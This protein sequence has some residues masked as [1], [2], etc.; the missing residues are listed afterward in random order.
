[1]GQLAHQVKAFIAQT[2]MELPQ[3][4]VSPDLRKLLQNRG[5]VATGSRHSTLTQRFIYRRNRLAQIEFRIRSLPPW[6]L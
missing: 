5:A 1:M 6:V 3:S 2:L 4:M